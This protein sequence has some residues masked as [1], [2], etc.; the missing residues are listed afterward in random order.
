MLRLYV[1]IVMVRLVKG[2]RSSAASLAGIVYGDQ[3]LFTT[4]GTEE[5]GGG[6][7]FT[8]DDTDFREAEICANLRPLVL[9]D[10]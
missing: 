2:E 5:H 9:S 3:N 8:T 6:P 1:G 4:E 10:R 7:S